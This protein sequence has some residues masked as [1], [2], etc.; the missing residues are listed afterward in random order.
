MSG[1][2]SPGALDEAVRVLAYMREHGKEN[3]IIRREMFEQL[4]TGCCLLSELKRY[5]QH[6]RTGRACGW[7]DDVHVEG[8][9]GLTQREA[10]PCDCGLAELLAELAR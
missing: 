4:V 7:Y 2:P 1:P 5:L 9:D 3:F 8:P 10:G 6:N